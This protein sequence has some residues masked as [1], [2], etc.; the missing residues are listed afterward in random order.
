M[1]GVVLLGT[2]VLAACSGKPVKSETAPSSQPIVSVGEIPD[3][4]MT[5]GST[6]VVEIPVT[7]AEGYHVQ[8]NPASGEFLI[9]LQLDLDA[10]EGIEVGTPTYP[11]G[12]PHR[13]EGSEDVLS[14]YEGTFRVAVPIKTSRTGTIDVRGTLQFQACDARRCLFP[15]SVPVVLKVVVGG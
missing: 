14:T 1:I 4:S 12:V 5:P 9:P 8:A 6:A 10:V 7:V 13:L 15:A 2:S 11:V 3:L